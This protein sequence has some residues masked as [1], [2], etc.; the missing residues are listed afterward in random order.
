M[1]DSTV[2]NNKA[3][4]NSAFAYIGNNEDK[5]YSYIYYT[6][7]RVNIYR[8]NFI[9]NTG[10]YAALLYL[11]NSKDMDVEI[12][13]S[14]FQDNN[15]RAAFVI[16][17]PEIIK[18]GHFYIEWGNILTIKDCVFLHYTEYNDMLNL[19]VILNGE[20]IRPNVYLLLYAKMIYYVNIWNTTQ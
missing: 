15:V 5:Y 3:D 6:F 8:G 17:T 1:N 2:D 9:N 14:T 19:D 12:Q 7:Y 4:N 18:S 16:N 10:V 13:L 20:T 11:Y